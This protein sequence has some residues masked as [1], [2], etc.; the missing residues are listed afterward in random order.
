MEGVFQ[1]ARQMCIWY[2]TAL[3]AR[4]LDFIHTAVV[5]GEDL[6]ILP[7]RQSVL[8]QEQGQIYVRDADNLR[9]SQA[10]VLI[11]VTYQQRGLNECLWQ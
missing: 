8:E 5:T 4:G 11:G 3:K 10:V 1:T 9:K 2:R 6:K 7:M